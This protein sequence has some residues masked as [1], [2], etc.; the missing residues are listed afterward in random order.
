MAKLINQPPTIQRAKAPASLKR[1]GTTTPAT[2]DRA[3]S[4]LTG[5]MGVMKQQHL[6]VETGKI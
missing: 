5:S 3:D 1:N 2:S 6:L 4:G